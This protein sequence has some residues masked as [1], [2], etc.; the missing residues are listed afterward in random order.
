MINPLSPSERSENISFFVETIWRDDQGNVVANRLPGRVTKD[1][2]CS[3]VPVDDDAVEVLRNNGILGGLDY[4]SEAGLCL[5]GLLAFANVAVRFK[6]R[7]NVS[8][9]IPLDHPSSGHSDS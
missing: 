6:N 7:R 4:S 3:F 5:L 1:S 2:L 8:A 9:G